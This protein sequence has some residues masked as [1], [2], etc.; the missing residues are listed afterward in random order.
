MKQAR[1]FELGKVCVHGWTWNAVHDTTESDIREWRPYRESPRLMLLGC[2]WVR[3]LLLGEPITLATM[4]CG[5]LIVG[6]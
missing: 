6:R 3:A 1:P 2:C 4:A 5:L